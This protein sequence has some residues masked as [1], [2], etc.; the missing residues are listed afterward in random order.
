MEAF[1]VVNTVKTIQAQTDYALIF[2][3]NKGIYN[4]NDGRQYQVPPPHK[5]DHPN[6][7]VCYSNSGLFGSS[8]EAPLRTVADEVLASRDKGKVAGKGKRVGGYGEGRVCYDFVIV[9][10]KNSEPGEEAPIGAYLDPETGEVVVVGEANYDK[11]V[12]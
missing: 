6:I 9:D 4:A 5:E 3:G 12:E 11:S 1:K 7:M 8:D 2:D 10:K